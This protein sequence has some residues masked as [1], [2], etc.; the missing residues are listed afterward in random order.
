MLRV[1]TYPFALI[2][3][4]LGDFVHV[5]RDN[6]HVFALVVHVLRVFTYL[7]ALIEHVLGVFAYILSLIARVL[8]HKTCRL[9][10]FAYRF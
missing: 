4:V 8:P 9:L 6:I 5:L 10:P 1:F 2:G 3:Y 7:F